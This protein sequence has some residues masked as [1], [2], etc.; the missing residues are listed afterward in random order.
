MMGSIGFR[1]M[2]GSLQTGLPFVK[3]GYK[4]NRQDILWGPS[5]GLC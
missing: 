2:S 4:G 5:E 3:K 1:V